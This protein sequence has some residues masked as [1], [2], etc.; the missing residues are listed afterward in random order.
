MTANKESEP[1][2]KAEE[3]PIAAENECVSS[4]SM[5]RAYICQRDTKHLGNGFYSLHFKVTFLGICNL[6]S[7]KGTGI[8]KNVQNLNG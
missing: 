7:G 6:N 3:I 5:V 1:F 2:L 4:S 8:T